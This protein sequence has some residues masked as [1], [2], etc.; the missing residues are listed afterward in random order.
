MWLNPYNGPVDER[1][2]KGRL[3]PL[4]AEGSR[5]KVL[6]GLLLLALFVV[7]VSSVRLLWPNRAANDSQVCNTWRT[8]V[9]DEATDRAKLGRDSLNAHQLEAAVAEWERRISDHPSFLDKQGKRVTRP[10]ACNRP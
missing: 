9:L 2:K 4:L 10:A 1:R 3:L 6:L 8:K 5:K 7:V